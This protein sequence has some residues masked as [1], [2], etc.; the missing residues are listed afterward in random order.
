M[1]IEGMQADGVIL[2]ELGER[3]SRCRLDMQLTQAALAEQAGV[4]KSTVERV[5][6]GASTQVSTLIR[7][8]R[9]LG[10]VDGLQNIVPENVPRPMELLKQ[11]TKVRHRASAHRVK[12]PGVEWQWGDE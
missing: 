7:I 8:L 5:E 10:L 2:N 3:L 11:N 4:S 9:V 6:A 1:K 12:S